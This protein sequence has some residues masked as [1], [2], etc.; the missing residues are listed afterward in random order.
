MARLGVWLQLLPLD[1]VSKALSQ[2]PERGP[3]TPLAS[4]SLARARPAR[5]RPFR[6]SG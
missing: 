2:Q 6:L 3:H 4:F 1:M 5:D